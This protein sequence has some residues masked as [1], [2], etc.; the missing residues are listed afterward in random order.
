[1][2]GAARSALPPAALALLVLAGCYRVNPQLARPFND[3][4]GYRFANLG[5]AAEQDRDDDTF[6]VLTFS[7]GGTRAAAFAYG[8]MEALH[9]TTLGDGRTMLDEV[10]VISS[11]SG[12]SF[13]AA[14]Y[15]LFGPEQFFARFRDD[16]LYR[17]IERDLILRVAAP[18]N[19]P[20]LLS[21][22]YARGDLA[23]AYYDSAIFEG[24]TFDSVPR[25]RPFIMLN[26]TDI[27]V[28]A[29]F[30]FTQEH[31]DRIC[32][33]LNG[34][35]VARGVA[36]SS[37]FPVAF[38]PLTLKNY[39]AGA[40]DYDPPKWV[41]HAEHGDFDVNP[42]RFDLARTWRSYEDA[43]RRP[44]IHLSDGGLS[45]NIGLRSVENGIWLTRSIPVLDQ[46][47][48]GKI[49]RLVI[50][51]VDAK[52]R[53]EA[54][55][56]RS[57]RPPGIFTVLNAAATNPMENYS[58]D[59][60]ELT[61]LY[62]DQWS[63]DETSFAARQ[64]G[65]RQF[66]AQSCASAS[67]QHEACAAQV[68]ERC[69]KALAADEAMRPKKPAELYLIDLRFDAI[70]DQDAKRSLQHVDTRLQLPPEQVDLLVSWGRRLLLG[71]P[72]Y[73]ALVDSLGGRLPN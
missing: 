20:L 39:G 60:V 70:P 57:A 42:P 5:D 58:S 3:A 43:I 50:I 18:W 63:K 34:V 23:A 22:Y 65:C 32:S 73:G 36:A 48:N 71:S 66:A 13:T 30:S 4:Y 17:K 14:Y 7:G 19:W 35:P 16:V 52:P 25:H 47:N 37:A 9:G 56:D 46:V 40:C 44:Y 33:D 38:T 59:T 51:V 28:G 26:A 12:G 68:T 6:I 55:A 11:V 61:R 45:D 8:V 1:M 67:A 69:E 31:F 54:S 49:S 64:D 62:F 41:M 21:P 15:G 2:N 10:D 72:Q 27:G 29:T 24:R 53:T